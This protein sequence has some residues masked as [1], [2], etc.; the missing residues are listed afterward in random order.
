[1][2][3]CLSL[4]ANADV[5]LQAL[6]TQIDEA[7]YD[8][9]EITL[10]DRALIERELGDRPPELV[11][12]QM[13]GKS[14]KEK[15]REHVRRLLS[16]FILEALK[17]KRDGILPLS[18][19]TGHPT[20][21]DAVRRG[22]EETFG[23]EAALR[24]EGEIA[25][26]L[27]KEIGDWLDGPF[28]KWHTQLYNR[29]PVIWQISSSD[30]HNTF[31]VFLYIHKLDADTLRKVQTQ[32]LWNQRRVLESQA[33]SARAAEDYARAEDAEKAL[34][35]LEAFE[36]RLLA[37]IQGE[38]AFEAPEWAEGPYRGGVYDPVLDDGV[39][40]NIEPLQAA[41]ILRYKKMV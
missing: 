25:Q 35:V 20:A 8:L 30:Y 19:G 14:D 6:Q 24:M 2:N 1:V 32:Y 22:L 29:R 23:E 4:E 38:V 36:Q 9:Y 16:Y 17:G 12:P 11:W 41:E 33:E 10:E 5:H 3:L 39:K 40:V 7:V 34:E 26:V 18:P 28:I 31:N 13:E 27:G 37:V 21:L 15:R